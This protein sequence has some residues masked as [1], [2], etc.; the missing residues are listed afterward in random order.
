MT[1]RK[2][3]KAAGSRGG[4]SMGSGGPPSE[5]KS[6]SD[7]RTLRAMRTYMEKARH[8]AANRQDVFLLC[9]KAALAKAYDFAVS[10][11][12]S[13][14]AESAY[15]SVATLRSICED[16]IVLGLLHALPEPDARLIVA[17][18]IRHEVL[19][20][21]LVQERFFAANRAGQSVLSGSLSTASSIKTIEVELAAVWLR[22]GWQIRRGIMPPTRELAAKQGDGVL[23]TLYEFLFRFTSGVVHFNPQA[24]LRSGWGDPKVGVTF[25]ARNYQAYY[26]ALNQTYSLYLLCGYFERFATVLGPD[27]KCLAAVEELRA[28]LH[29]RERWPEIITHEEMNLEPPKFSIQGLLVRSAAALENPP[30]IRDAGPTLRRKG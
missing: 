29:R 2:G 3:V 12:R 25:R 19:S 15:F 5:R 27:R 9:L 23:A 28:S 4:D 21:V 1:R 20:K 6:E 13:S 18:M 14:R 26:L 22:N 24:L 16:L 7:T 30:L 17:G 8:G 10:A 11:H